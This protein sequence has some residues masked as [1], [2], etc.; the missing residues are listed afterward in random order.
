MN[1][2]LIW[3]LI[4]LWPSQ[5]AVTQTQVKEKNTFFGCTFDLNDTSQ[6]STDVNVT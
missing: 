6:S 2:S 1:A 5:H 4:E 3:K